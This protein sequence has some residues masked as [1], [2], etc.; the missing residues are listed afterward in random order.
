MMNGTKWLQ[1]HVG[2]VGAKIST[3]GLEYVHKIV[4]LSGIQ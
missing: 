4:F 1:I 2:E 3:S